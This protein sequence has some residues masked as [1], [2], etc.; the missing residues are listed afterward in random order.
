MEALG[1]VVAGEFGMDEDFFADADL[2]AVL[3]LGGDEGRRLEK[4]EREGIDGPAEEGDVVDMLVLVGIAPEGAEGGGGGGGG[5]GSER[6]GE[7]GNGVAGVGGEG[8]DGIGDALGTAGGEIDNDPETG[9][10]GEDEAVVV[11]QNIVAVGAGAA[12]ARAGPSFDVD[13]V[14]EASVGIDIET[15]LGEHPGLAGLAQFF[16]GDRESSGVAGGGVL[17][18]APAGGGSETKSGVSI[19]KTDAGGEAKDTERHA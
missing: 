19:E 1:D 13:G 12:D 4:G 6:G 15:H 7:R 11:L 5:G 9:S 16:R 17:E 14:A 8:G 2:G 3:D 18:D 10:A